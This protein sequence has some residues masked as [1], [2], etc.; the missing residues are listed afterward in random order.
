M[1][2]RIYRERDFGKMG[3]KARELKRRI[4]NAGDE[5][6][7]GWQ[8]GKDFTVL[9]LDETSQHPTFIRARH[10]TRQDLKVEV[11]HH[12][13]PDIFCEWM[14]VLF[15]FDGEVPEK[16]INAIVQ[17]LELEEQKPSLLRRAKAVRD[18]IP[19]LQKVGA[20]ER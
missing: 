7:Q 13:I 11:H 9:F 8:D 20:V 5:W 10:T 2:I 16:E 6:Q 3:A 17:G 15:K 4:L 14:E 12:K 1:R 18:E 19:M